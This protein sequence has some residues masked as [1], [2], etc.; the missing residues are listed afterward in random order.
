[1]VFLCW[2]F[3]WTGHGSGRMAVPGCFLRAVF[4]NLRLTALIVESASSSPTGRGLCPAGPSAGPSGERQ[5]L[6]MFTQGL[7]PPKKTASASF[8]LSGGGFLP[9]RQEI[10]LDT[11][12]SSTET[13]TDVD[14]PRGKTP[15][16]TACVFFFFFLVFLGP[17][18]PHMEVPR[19][20]V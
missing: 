5:S 18:L 15:L 16:W 14:T 6:P 8:P 7:A 2:A 1:M 12:T 19:L 4:T 3:P 20:G 17:H 13:R 11:K 9:E 10:S